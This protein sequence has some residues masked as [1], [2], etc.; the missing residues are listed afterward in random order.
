M[1]VHTH[2]CD[3]FVHV[4]WPSVVSPPRA[5]VILTKL[6]IRMWCDQLRAAV[7][8]ACTYFSHVSVSSSA[9]VFACLAQLTIN[10]QTE[11]QL[12]RGYVCQSTCSSFRSEDEFFRALY[13]CVCMPK[14]PVPLY[15]GRGGQGVEAT[16][17]LGKGQRHERMCGILTVCMRAVYLIVGFFLFGMAMAI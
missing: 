6:R 5:L 8:L 9:S 17:Y 11:A 13:D 12:R 16:G 2:S 14:R 7:T 3:N 15:R 4:T 10:L 1:W